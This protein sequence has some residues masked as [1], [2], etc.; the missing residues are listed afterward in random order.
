MGSI[1]LNAENEDPG[2]G[3]RFVVHEIGGIE[4]L[5]QKVHGADIAVTQL[6]TAPCRGSLVHAIDD[7]MAM[8]LGCFSGDLRLRGV[9][10]PEA[11]TLALILEQD[12]SL[13]EWGLDTRAHDLV[14]FP[15]RG[16]Q[17]ANCQGVTRYAALK[18]PIEA[19]QQRAVAFEHLADDHRWRAEARLRS[20]RGETIGPRVG[21][22]LE[23][24]LQLGPWL[25]PQ[26]L[27]RLRDE[28]VDGFLRVAAAAT[29][30]EPGP[31]VWINSARILRRVEDHLDACPGRSVSIPELCQA[32]A[33]SR[34][35]LNRAFEEGLGVG[36]KTYL[37]LRALSAARKALVAGRDVGASVTQVALDHGFWELGRFSVTYRAMFGESPSQTLRGAQ[38]MRA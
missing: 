38:V 3:M 16:E 33:L 15:V 8:T 6:T 11:V 18:M 37:R 34:R 21:Q 17:E 10:S 35:T 32:L 1:S 31:Q 29:D 4:D 27:T 14:I 20:P 30:R 25:E 36:P 9:M 7:D 13:T 22:S 23:R 28:V 19:L 12:R 5:R 26:A 2:A 24:L